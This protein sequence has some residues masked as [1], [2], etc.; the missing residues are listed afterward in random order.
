M[1]IKLNV[2]YI[3]SSDSTHPIVLSKKANLN[4]EKKKY[5][6]SYLG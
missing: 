2:K 6:L 3:P 1:L 5:V 4:N